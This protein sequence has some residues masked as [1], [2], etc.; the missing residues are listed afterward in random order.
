MTDA[1][2]KKYTVCI[3]YIASKI[4]EVE[5]KDADQAEAIA[6]RQATEVAPYDDLSITVGYVDEEDEDV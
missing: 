6:M 5:A 1:K 2:L 4:Y 3:D